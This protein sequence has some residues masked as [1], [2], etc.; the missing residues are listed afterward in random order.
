M[1]FGANQAVLEKGN[2][3]KLF[4]SSFFYGTYGKEGHFPAL[5][6]FYGTCEFAD[7]AELPVRDG[8]VDQILEFEG[9]EALE[10]VEAKIHP[11]DEG[12]Y[13]H[14]DFSF[15]YSRLPTRMYTHNYSI[16]S[17]DLF[18]VGHHGSLEECIDEIR[19]CA[20]L[21]HLNLVH[22][23]RQQDE[24]DIEEGFFHIDLLGDPFNDAMGIMHMYPWEV[25]P[26]LRDNYLVPVID[27]LAN[28]RDG[29]VAALNAEVLKS[30]RRN[31]AEPVVKHMTDNV[32]VYDLFTCGLLDSY[33]RLISELQFSESDNFRRAQKIWDRILEST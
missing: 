3:E 28:G 1:G 19:E 25:E 5:V 14:D 32:V 18:K 4:G 33:M 9:G 15:Y 22:Q 27:A 30:F 20:R 29:T 6:I 11:L 8:F 17:E 26:F 16:K 2:P 7:F 31:Y 24:E 12:L 13:V 21:Y 10:T 23:M